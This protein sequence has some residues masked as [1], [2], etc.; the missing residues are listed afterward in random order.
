MVPENDT[1]YTQDT[2]SGKRQVRLGVLEW[3]GLN[4][5]KNEQF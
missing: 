4:A 3:V 2:F 1:K 5:G